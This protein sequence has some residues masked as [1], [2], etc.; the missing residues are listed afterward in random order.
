MILIV[1]TPGDDHASA[2]IAELSKRGARSHLL[3]LSEFPQQLALRMEYNAGQNSFSFGCSGS[4]GLNLAD[5]RSVW[6]RRPQWPQVSPQIVR[7]AHRD[8]AYNESIEALHGLWHSLQPFW[9]NDPARD[10]VAQRKAFQLKAAGQAGLTVPETLI[11]NCA[12][13]AQEFVAR[14]GHERV[15]YKS[16]SALEHEW[17]ETRV[18][19]SDEISLLDNVRYAP[20]IFQEYVEAQVDLRVTIVGEQIFAAAIHSQETSYQVDCRMDMAN[21]HVEPITL[22]DEVQQRLH[23]LTDS[24]GLVYGAID[25]RLRPDGEYVFFEINPAGQWR[26]IEVLTGQPITAA[27]AELLHA[28]DRM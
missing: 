19:A 7:A 5:C 22:P 18:L 4:G 1:S 27:M 24:L 13:A 11:T 28:H 26:F 9:I 8:F 15:I 2:V 21:A 6:W 3:D 12:P 14:H 17:R 20:V 10:Y 16:F 25:M 23:A